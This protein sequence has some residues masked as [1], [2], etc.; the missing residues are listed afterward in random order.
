MLVLTRKAHQSIFLTAPAGGIPAGTRIVV[1]ITKIE[2]GHA[3]VG[4]DAPRN[5]VVLREELA[6][7]AN[8]EG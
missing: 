6:N 1:T 8:R 2:N 3:V 5:V 4:V 7:L